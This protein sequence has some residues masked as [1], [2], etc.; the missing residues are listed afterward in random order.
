MKLYRINEVDTKVIKYIRDVVA[1]I[2]YH[3]NRDRFY[4]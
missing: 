2:G 3:R 4:L 1:L